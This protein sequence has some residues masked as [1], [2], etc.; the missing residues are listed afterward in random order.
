M[1]K[2]S[3]LISNSI[4]VYRKE[5]SGYLRK[6]SEQGGSS[7]EHG[8]NWNAGKVVDQRNHTSKQYQD[9]NDLHSCTL[10]MTLLGTAY[11]HIQL[12]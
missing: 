1:A 6:T 5:L 9:Q 7:A 11:L 2:I 8:H 4:I 3:N 12:F 10:Y